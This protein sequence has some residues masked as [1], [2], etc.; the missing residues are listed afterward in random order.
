MR[1]IMSIA[2]AGYDGPN[3]AQNGMS[4]LSGFFVSVFSFV[5]FL[6]PPKLI[7]YTILNVKFLPSV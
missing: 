6:E 3:A 4:V 1:Y 2:G 5:F 7:L